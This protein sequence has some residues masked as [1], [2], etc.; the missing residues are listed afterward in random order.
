[1][2]NEKS[3][4]EHTFAF[5]GAGNMA[6]AFIYGFI[7]NR[8][9]KPNDIIVHRKDHS[10]NAPLIS[11][12]VHICDDYARTFS[13]SKYI[14]LAVKPYQLE[15]VLKELAESGADYSRSVFVSVCA[16]VPCELICRWLG[17]DVPVVR[18]MPSTPITVGR[19]TAA[20]SHNSFVDKKEFQLLCRMISSVAEV[21]VIP[22][23]AQNPVISVNGSS[24]AY[25]YLFV[26]AMVDAAAL[27]GIEPTASLP[28]IL[29]TMEG[30][31]EMIRKSNKSIDELIREVSS[32]GGTT[33]AALKVFDD[34]DVTGIISD[35]MKA[36]T[37]RA[38]EI[39]EDL[40]AK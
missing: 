29:R 31:A 8:V 34:R 23:E 39:T 26:K 33:L 15:G 6:S 22:E 5:I 27:Q 7:D 35:A 11:R 20:V 13:S 28:L 38:D 10:K 40:C 24:P 1:M 25:F 17:T 37:D 16:A 4:F 9:C 18:V 21:A 12:G 36:C 2:S 3:A 19:G 32:P 30:S 14:F